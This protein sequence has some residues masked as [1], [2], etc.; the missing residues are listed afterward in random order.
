MKKKK[1]TKNLLR[2][3]NHEFTVQTEGITKCP[4]Q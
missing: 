1:T 3:E 2:I 4:T